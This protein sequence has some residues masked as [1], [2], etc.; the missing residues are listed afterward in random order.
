MGLRMR[1]VAIGIVQLVVVASVLLGLY[2][3]EAKDKARQ[4][5]V[6]KSRS[7]VLSAESARE[8]MAKKWDLG[9][10]SAEQLSQWAREGHIG[11]ILAAVP[12]VTAWNTAMLKAEEGGYQFRVPKFQPR[13]PKNEPD[14]LEAGVLRLFEQEGVSEHY[15]VDESMNAV[16]YFR[17][18]RL[19]QECLLCHGQPSR[20]A[21]LWGQ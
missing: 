5:F 4:Q 1:I 20:S 16:R 9:V 10:F 14:E 3:F 11:K 13:N 18:I 8:E 17:P 15:V 12:V 6:E 2:Y 21:E 19:T 7:I